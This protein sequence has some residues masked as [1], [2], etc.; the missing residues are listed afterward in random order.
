MG[1]EFGYCRFKGRRRHLYHFSEFGKRPCFVD[2]QPFFLEQPDHVLHV[3][4]LLRLRRIEDQGIFR[5]WLDGHRFA[6][7]NI[8]ER[9]VHEPLSFGV[10]CHHVRQPWRGIAACGVIGADGGDV[11]RFVPA[12]L[13][14]PRPCRKRGHHAVAC[15]RGA[16]AYHHFVGI[17]AYEQLEQALFP[18]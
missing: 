8:A 2:G 14:K 4:V 15:G 6:V 9:L 18:A 11:Q 13:A 3:G 7:S 12:D 1:V 17:G 16:S 10:D 5:A